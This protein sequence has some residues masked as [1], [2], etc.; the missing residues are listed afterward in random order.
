MGKE[1]LSFLKKCKQ[2][3]LHL[4]IFLYPYKMYIINEVLSNLVTCQSKDAYITIFYCVFIAI[5]Q[6]F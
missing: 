6:E 1:K 2:E 3:N 5:R 4:H